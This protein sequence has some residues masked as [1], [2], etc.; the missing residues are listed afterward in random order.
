MIARGSGFAPV[1]AWT[2]TLLCFSCCPF[3]R[4][5]ELPIRRIV[6]YT[7]GV[8]FFERQG[9]VQDTETVELVFPSDEINDLLKSMV[10]QDRGGGTVSRITYGSPTPLSYA[11]SSFAVDLADNPTLADLLDQLR[12]TP[13]R[14]TTSKVYEGTIVG[15]EIRADGPVEQPHETTW[16]NLLTEQGLQ[17]LELTTLQA[18]QVLDPDLERQFRLALAEV[19]KTRR[20]DLQPVSIELRGTGQRPVTVGYIRE[21]PVWKVSYR[22][23][24]STDKRPFLQGW[25][26][27]ENTTDEDWTDVQLSLVSGRPISFVMELDQ[28]LY[29]ER[30]HLL[31]D[32]YGTVAP[33]VYDRGR[34]AAPPESWPGSG[35]GMGGMGGGMG[36]MGGMGGSMGGMGGMGGWVPPG[37]NSR[38]TPG[39]ENDTRE[40]R[41]EIAE[42]VAP[43]VSTEEVGELFRYDVDLP[44][45]LSRNRSAMFPIVNSPLAGEGVSIYSQ[46]MHPVHPMR[47]LKL[48]NDTD[49]YLMQG[50]ITVFDEGTYAGDSRV[51]DLAPGESRLISYALDVDLDVTLSS[52]TSSLSLTKLSIR[53]GL[54]NTTHETVRTT[55]YS[56]ETRADTPRQLVIEQPLK[57]GFELSARDALEE[58]TSTTYR[59]RIPVEPGL[60]VKFVVRE[61]STTKADVPLASLD[62]AILRTHLGNAALR[63]PTKGVI[64]KVLDMRAEQAERAADL[65]HQRNALREIMSAQTRIRENMKALDRTSELYQQYVQTMTDQER[66]ISDLAKQIQDLDAGNLQREQALDRYLKE[67]S[68]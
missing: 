48:T 58:T 20:E 62:E 47:G 49:L 55:T 43:D 45:S 61:V 21:F 53:K 27:V 22:L 29:V 34:A 40:D 37:P 67:A 13:V 5:A 59:F 10:V 46:Q 16:L 66:Q 30:P 18:V 39:P 38:P 14:C 63:E 23:V 19:A 41:L 4:A 35:G 57:E 28:P 8:G 36:G 11:L 68:E 1:A 9:D 33:R 64:Q 26:I 6:L 65:T 31:P 32:V 12:G 15:L 2:A 52:D 3:G 56:I 42:S 25:A 60:P 7:A 50:P 51:R 24:L 54:V 44:V 17:S